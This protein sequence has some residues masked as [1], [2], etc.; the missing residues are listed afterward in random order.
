M[1]FEAIPDRT[2]VRTR[3]ASR[4]YV[5]LFIEAPASLGERARPPVNLAVVV[6]RSG[7]MDGEKIERAREAAL[8]TVRSL[9]DGDCLG[10]VAY[11][12]RVDVLLPSAA[13][14]ARTR[15]DAE[16]AISRLHAR[17]MTNLCEGWLRG[18][19]QAARQLGEGRVGRALLMSDGLAN[20]GITDADEIVS[21]AAALR[22]R[23]VS[24]STFGIGRDFDE[25]LLAR[26]AESGG[27]N[28]YYV[29]GA[30]QI[31]A[32]VAAEVGESLDV[33]ARDAA[34]VVHAPEGASVR[35]LNGYPVTAQG[36]RWRVALGALVSR[37]QLEPALEIR[38]PAGARGDTAAVVVSLDDAD[39]VL[40]GAPVELGYRYAGDAENDAQPRDVEVDRQVAAL[41]A[42][43]VRREALRLNRDGRFDAARAT[44]LACGERIAGYAGDDARLGEI[45]RSVRASAEQYREEL[46]VHTRKEAYSVAM[47]SMKSRSA[48]GASLRAGDGRRLVVQPLHR[49]TRELVERAVRGAHPALRELFTAVDVDPRLVEAWEHHDD[50]GG[51]LAPDAEADIVAAAVDA[52][53]GP[54]VRIVTTRRRL[55]DNWFSHWHAPQ[56]T[57]VSS[58]FA[59]DRTA[60]VAAEAFVVYEI[61]L[62]GLHGLSRRFDPL[63]LAHEETRGCLFDFCGL[64]ADIEIKLQTMDLCPACERQLAAR[65]IDLDA[66]RGVCESVRVLAR[67][68]AARVAEIG[69]QRPAV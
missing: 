45:L 56:R 26:M 34:V 30:E 3:G 31:P 54:E 10:V 28:F 44:L 16:D 15:R 25:D 29:D 6:D 58:L 62:Y 24:T 53:S 43:A 61:L 20:R 36:T 55:A 14:D 13:V 42:S 23:G 2:L 59:W 9:R 69:G 18:C 68:L 35:S 49:E 12:D 66:V 52:A 60:A 65:R 17:G 8:H 51:E 57:A 22:A 50:P 48:R 7:S 27:G 5:K 19:E 40:D 64:R 38:F 1:T 41:F 46:A 4:R 37:Q 39:G 21:H 47:Y 63:D 32:Y 11:D 67:P 33:V